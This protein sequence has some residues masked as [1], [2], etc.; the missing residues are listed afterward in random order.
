[1][2]KLIL[3]ICLALLLSISGTLR[4]DVF[5]LGSG[6]TNMDTVPIGDLSNAPDTRF[7]GSYGSVAYSYRIGKYEVT[8]AQY[9]DFLNYK[10]K[11]D[12]YSL[13]NTKM[14]DT[15]GHNG[16][17]IQRIG[18]S[19]SYSYSVSADWAN[20]PVNYISFWDACRFANW[21]GNGQGNGD[22]ETGAYTLNGYMGSDGHT[23]TRNPQ[24]TWC[25]PSEDEWYKAGYYKSGGINSGYWTYATQ[26]DTRPSNVCN[27]PDPG[28]TAN[29][30]YNNVYT[31]G[32]P[33]Y[34]NI[35]GQ[36]S[37]SASAYGTFDQEGNVWEWNEAVVQNGSNLYRGMRGGAFILND[38]YLPASYRGSYNPASNQDYDLG[39][40]I[41][42]V[43]VPTVQGV[44]ALQWYTGSIGGI[45]GK[46]EIQSTTGAVLE[47]HSI[48]LDSAGNFS[49][50]PSQPDGRYKLVAKCS[51]WL[52]R[53]L[54]MTLSNGQATVNF[55]GSTKLLNGD[56]NG[57]NAVEDLDYSIL[58]AAW[59]SSAG[60]A[61]YSPNADLN[62]D[63]FVEDQDYSIMGDNW[64][65][66]GDP[67]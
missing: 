13:Y 16:C 48:V 36:F 9:A 62:G 21:L 19:G 22:T 66:T 65:V 17:N 61:N 38:Y 24:A 3:P 32:S 8:A 46:V 39:F 7:G 33:Y 37:D 11:S 43:G 26:S 44:I 63:G 67:F 59:Y 60:D 15:A 42:V 5:N 45:Q 54:P 20:R 30:Y 47:T 12:P 4:A 50:T 28:N 25:I 35:V 18:S 64:Y 40:R 14:S 31:I 51:H 55:I 23:I 56:V 52:A 41:A 6:L 10:A 34:M 49:F 53:S 57:D 1:M 27:T 29:Y 2:G 58:G